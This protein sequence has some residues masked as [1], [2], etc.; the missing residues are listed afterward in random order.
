MTDSQLKITAM[1]ILVK[2][3]GIVNAQRFISLVIKDKLD[4]TKWQSDLYSNKNVDEVFDSAS[5]FKG[6]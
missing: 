5:K 1:N 4:Y 6:T 2:N 3:L